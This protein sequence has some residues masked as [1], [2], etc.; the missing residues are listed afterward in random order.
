VPATFPAPFPRLVAMGLIATACATVPP[1][2]LGSRTPLRSPYLLGAS[3]ISGVKVNSAYDAVQRLKPNFLGG[4][5]GQDFIH[6]VVYLDG[7]RLRGGL[8]NLR[9]IEASS[10][11]QIVFLSA[12]EASGRYGPGNGAGALLVTTWAGSRLP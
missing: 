7:T 12:I 11:R 9:M 1:A 5:R 10:V 2:Q 8:E 6:R 4:M 3:E